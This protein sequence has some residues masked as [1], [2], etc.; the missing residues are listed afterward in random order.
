[1]NPDPRAPAPF[2][3]MRSITKHYGTVIAN[4]AVD[5]D[6]YPGEIHALVGENGSGKSTLMHVLSGYAS[7]DSG[8]VLL[9]GKPVEFPSPAAALEAGIGMVHQKPSLI[10]ELS[11]AANLRLA[12][13]FAKRE[14]DE[15]YTG[16]V[17]RYRISLDTGATA[18][19]I[20]DAAKEYVSLVAL[21]MRSLRL[22][23]LD[24]PSGSFS[25]EDEARYFDIVKSIASTGAAVVFI[26][27]K[28]KEITRIADRMT[29][30]RKGRAVVS[31]M[32]TA[33]TDDQ[34][35][36]IVFGDA[37][38]ETFPGGRKHRVPGRE[39][40]T[41]DRVGRDVPGEPRLDDATFAVREG[42]VVVVAGLRDHGPDT[43]ARIVTGEAVPS[44]G[45]I[46]FDGKR[47]RSMTRRLLRNAGVG[48]V[49]SD[50]FG[51][52][53]ATADLI[54]ENLVAVKRTTVHRRGVLDRRKALRL[55]ESLLERAGVNAQAERAISTLSGGMTQRILFARELD[56]ATKLLVVSE[57]FWG[58]DGEGRN[59][60]IERIGDLASSSVAV[61]IFV[62]DIDDITPIA[63]TVIVFRA[64]RI[65]AVVDAA[66]ASREH[67][68]N[69]VLGFG[70]GTGAASGPDIGVGVGSR[71]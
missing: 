9:D 42:E 22:Y 1:V 23:I 10:N 48:E 58:L 29:V 32:T 3:V 64:G 26:T 12:S 17:A 61:L 46:T 33:R 45:T 27:H 15:R 37:T 59:R 44:S 41:F 7:R 36:S 71:A 65:A 69:L 16:I 52:G 5:L 53:V 34:I 63:D 25:L 57:P 11:I 40:L 62:S 14:F 43:L 31:E 50:R 24:E 8:S 47:Y 35:R 19:S 2:L 54:W 60:M 67:I 6:V 55:A 20:S 51:T 39:V 68:G 49:P 21:L 56:A 4:D 38:R 18:G 28:I 66:D 13:P 70:L 30:M